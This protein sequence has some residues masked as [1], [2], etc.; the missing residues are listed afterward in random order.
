MKKL[1]KGLLAVVVFVSSVFLFGNKADHPSQNN[2]TALSQDGKSHRL[3]LQHAR[4]IFSKLDA[5][6]A[7][8]YHYSHSSHGSHGSH[9]SHSSNG[10]PW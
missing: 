4:D 1:I 8:A 2:Q 6:S 3:I 5:S 7:M 10:W 9:G